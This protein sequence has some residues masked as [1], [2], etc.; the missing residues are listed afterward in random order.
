MLPV[1]KIKIND[2]ELGVAKMSLVESPAIESDFIALAQDKKPL[3]F[4]VD[5]E[6]H[7]VFGCALRANYLIY[8]NSLGGQNTDYYVVFEPD[9]IKEIVQKFFRE[10][11]I[12]LVNLEH[13]QDTTGCYLYTS[14]IKDTSKGI[15]PV[16]F[17][18]IDDGSWFVGYK[19]EN[20]EVWSAI[21]AGHFKGFSVEGL[22]DFEPKDEID[23]I[24]DELD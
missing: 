16:G 2:C 15:N 6:Q 18:D 12:N 9:T 11:R 4:S 17:E 10:N 20:P 5:E 24:M 1:Y 7:I 13:S 8:R 23:E 21:K 14:F 3:Q 19:I 22:F